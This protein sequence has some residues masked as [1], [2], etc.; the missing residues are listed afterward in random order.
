MRHALEAIERNTLLQA[1]LIDDLL[2][3]SRAV[4]GKLDFVVARLDL[5]EVLRQTVH[6]FEPK[7][8]AAAVAIE[9]TTASGLWV[10]G[11]PLRLQQV[12]GNLLAN[13]LTFTPPGGSVH[14]DG[15]RHED[16]VELVVRDTGKGIDADTLPHVFELFYQGSP[17]LRHRQGLGLGLT[18]AKHIVDVHGGT[19]TAESPGLGLGTTFTVRFPFAT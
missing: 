6:S 17:G 12:A 18:I 8:Q 11:D 13:A 4:A 1:R 15:D 3:V 9:L 16:I 19:I 14:V 10:I 2:D 7:A 5:A